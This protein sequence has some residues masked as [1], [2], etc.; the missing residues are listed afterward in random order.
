MAYDKVVDSSVL[1]AGLTAIA[2][3][4]RAKA[5]TSGSL[6]FPTAMA[7]AIAAIEAGGGAVVG[8]GTFTPSADISTE[9]RYDFPHNLGVTPDTFVLYKKDTTVQFIQFL[10][11]EGNTCWSVCSN[12]YKVCFNEETIIGYGANNRL[13]ATYAPLYTDSSIGILK[14]GVEYSWMAVAEG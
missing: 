4:I 14:A 6:A 12:A 5:G 3:A 1:D 9:N 7:E 2:D 11:V 8:R 10:L 13:N